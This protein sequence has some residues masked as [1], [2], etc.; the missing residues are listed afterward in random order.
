M[1]DILVSVVIPVYNCEPYITQCLKS[2]CSQTLKNIE[3]IV[4][5]DCSTD[6]TLKK[7]PKDPRI[8]TI[9]SIQ[10]TDSGTLR[11]KGINIARGKYIAF[12]D[13]DDFF[14][15]SDSLK[16]LSK[17]ALDNNLDIVGGSL[18]TF[19]SNTG[20]K[21]YLIPG[22]FFLKEGYLNYKKYQHDGGFYRFIY[23]REYLLSRNIMFPNFKRMQDPVFFVNA[24][25]NTRN[26]YVIPDYVYAYRK[27]HKSVKWDDQQII[28]KFKAIDLILKISKR[29]DLSH[30]HF[31]M[32]KNFVNF[33]NQHLPELR[34]FKNQTKIF[35][36]IC[37]E[38]D[39]DLLN[40]SSKNDRIKFLR[41]K[42][43]GVFLK[44]LFFVWKE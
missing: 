25:I 32:V 29:H 41:L 22:Q 2:V 40:R 13:G 16:K 18:F 35:F 5:D 19:N 23:N 33:S 17:L 36:N 7:I 24:M 39:F 28:D 12:L 4:L 14:P 1:S 21:K 6:S 15:D 44:S 10:K 38:I 43:V 11:N 26:I 20:E 27:C 37:N 30:L 42:L 3:I 8:I 9:Q 34:N 31:L